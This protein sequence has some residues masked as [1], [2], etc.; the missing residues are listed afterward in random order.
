MFIDN[1]KS[2]FQVNQE[3]IR[4]FWVLRLLHVGSL[5]TCLG[6][7]TGGSKVP[8]GGRGLIHSV[9]EPQHRNHLKACHRRLP[10]PSLG[11]R[12]QVRR[13]PKFA[14]LTSSQV[15]LRLLVPDRTLRATGLEPTHSPK[16]NGD[17]SSPE[18]CVHANP[19]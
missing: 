4:A 8:G 15:V 18:E 9:P 10:G 1:E 14:L 19:S 5:F 6:K 11:I 12:H 7:R 2:E 3:E 17:E 16:T 13:R